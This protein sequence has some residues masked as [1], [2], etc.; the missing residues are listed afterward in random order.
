MDEVRKHR[1]AIYNVICYKINYLGRSSGSKD[2]MKE[3]KIA[4]SVIL[5]LFICSMKYVTTLQCPCPIVPASAE[6]CF[7]TDAES[8]NVICVLLPFQE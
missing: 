4:D 2:Y 1:R 6:F 8:A 7:Q 3:K 5:N